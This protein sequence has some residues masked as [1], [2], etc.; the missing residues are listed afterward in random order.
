MISRLQKRLDRVLHLS[1][2]F[3]LLQ[4]PFFPKLP[5]ALQRFPFFLSSCDQGDAVNAEHPCLHLEGARKASG[6]A[7]T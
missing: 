6:P 1:K 7:E 3:C 2:T 4:V 5:P